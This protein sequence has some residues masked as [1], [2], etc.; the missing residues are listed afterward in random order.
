MAKKLKRPRDT[1]QLAKNIV[2]IATGEVQEIKKETTD[3]L[4]SAAALLGRK[5]G[6]KG[7]KARAKALSAKK[8]KE[9]AKKAAAAR[10]SRKNK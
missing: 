9:I 1:N 6:L 3:E 2:D 8:R 5:G 10:W 7:G 4:K